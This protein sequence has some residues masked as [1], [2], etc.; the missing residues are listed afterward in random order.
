VSSASVGGD[1]G[2][3][4]PEP[5]PA[6][7][8]VPKEDSA[9]HDDKPKQ[10]GTPKD[11]LREYAKVGMGSADTFWPPQL[12]L[13]KDLT[14]KSGKLAYDKSGDIYV[15]DFATATET[16]LTQKQQHN[17]VP[18]FFHDGHRIAFLSNREAGLYGVYVMELGAPTAKLVTG[19]SKEPFEFAISPDDKLIAYVQKIGES[20]SGRMHLVDLESGR[21]DTL[22]Q[23]LGEFQGVKHPTF[24]PTGDELYFAQNGWDDERVFAAHVA[25]RM[26]RNVTR[27]GTWYNA[28][29]KIGERVLVGLGGTQSYCCREMTLVTMAKDGSDQRTLPTSFGVAGG[30]YPK[31]S[32]KGT[33]IAAA[34]SA[35]LGGF[36]SDWRVEITIL[37]AD[38]SHPHMLGEMFPHPFY[39]VSAPSWAADDHHIALDLS[40]CPY[41]GCEPGMRSVVVVDTDHPKDVPAFISYGGSP[42]FSPVP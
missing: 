28:P 31:L 6:T 10:I 9:E 20:F 13:P 12:R 40:I 27:T 41:M 8:F 37:D 38:G 4:A 42:D 16:R 36:G 15:F 3:A 17:V 26:V 39:S 25:T 35:R 29:Q 23:A 19:K 11:W 32:P 22:T 5:P 24:S 2:S 18:R 1:A 33:K 30:I 7:P 14:L 21:D 34:W